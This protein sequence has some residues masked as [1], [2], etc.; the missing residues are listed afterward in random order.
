MLMF[1]KQKLSQHRRWRLDLPGARYYLFLP[2]VM[3]NPS[4][5][6]AFLLL[7]RPLA[8]WTG[9]FLLGILLILPKPRLWLRAVSR[10]LQVVTSSLERWHLNWP[11]VLGLALAGLRLGIALDYPEG[12][13]GLLT[14]QDTKTK[15]ILTVTL[16]WCLVSGFMLR[17]VEQ[18][19]G[20]V[21]FLNSALRY[22][23][24]FRS[25]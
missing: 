7:L 20:L 23:L 19:E 21:Q 11:I 4:T 18:H 9:L 8:I 13:P 17:I 3:R 10:W 15:W 22:L 25:F 14:F 12:I 5:P 16:L 24:Y 2:L 1:R 6:P